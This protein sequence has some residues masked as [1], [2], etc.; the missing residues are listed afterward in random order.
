MKRANS[1]YTQTDPSFKGKLL[2]LA[3]IWLL[4]EEALWN[5]LDGTISSDVGWVCIPLD[6]CQMG[7]ISSCLARREAFIVNTPTED[8]CIMIFSHY[9]QRFF[10]HTY[11]LKREREESFNTVVAC[12]QC[13]LSSETMCLR[14]ENITLHSVNQRRQDTLS[15]HLNSFCFHW[16]THTHIHTQFL[17]PY[18]FSHVSCIINLC[19]LLLTFSAFAF[20][21]P[22]VQPSCLAMSQ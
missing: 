11:V 14:G 21:Q 4:N 3:S 13:H 9:I 5:Q 19:M 18:A 7:T 22:P 10:F 1:D 15:G 6:L 8:F 2:N 20:H 12:M 17:T 16:H